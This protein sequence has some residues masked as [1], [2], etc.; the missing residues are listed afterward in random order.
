MMG[1]FT[2]HP[3]EEMLG[4]V[5]MPGARPG[6]ERLAFPGG[7]LKVRPLLSAQFSVSI[8]ASWRG[9]TRHMRFNPVAADVSGGKRSS[10]MRI[11][12]S[13]TLSRFARKSAESASDFASVVHNLILDVRDSQHH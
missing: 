6:H 7:K 9:R 4:D 12:N 10:P 3:A 13:N 1:S 11:I 2:A 8:A 5:E